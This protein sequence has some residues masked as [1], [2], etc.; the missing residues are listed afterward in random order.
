MIAIYNELDGFW[1]V[2]DDEGF[3]VAGPFDTE[4]DAWDYIDGWDELA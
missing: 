2:A 1:F 3:E 4:Q